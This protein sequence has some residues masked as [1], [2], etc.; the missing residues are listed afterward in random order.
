MTVV[1]EFLQDFFALPEEAADE[2][3]VGKRDAER[4]GASLGEQ[5]AS[6]A[7]QSEIQAVLEQAVAA[8]SAVEAALA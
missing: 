6:K 1:P 3:E 4:A 2:A 5:W 7:T 8:K